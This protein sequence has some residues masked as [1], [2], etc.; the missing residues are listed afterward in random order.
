MDRE[1]DWYAFLDKMSDEELMEELSNYSAEELQVFCIN[2]IRGWAFHQ[3]QTE[4]RSE[5]F[6]RELVSLLQ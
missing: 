1:F 5:Q 2:I 6:Y 3:K 4:I